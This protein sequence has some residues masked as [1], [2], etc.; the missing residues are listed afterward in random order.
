[1]NVACACQYSFTQQTRMMHTPL[2]AP[3]QK[4]AAIPRKSHPPINSGRGGNPR[5][6]HPG[7]PSANGAGIRRPKS[8]HHVARG[9]PPPPPSSWLPPVTFFPS[10]PPLL[11][12]WFRTSPTEASATPTTTNEDRR[13]TD[14]GFRA[15]PRPAPP[16]AS[17]YG[18]PLPPRQPLSL[19]CLLFDS[20]SRRGGPISPRAAAVAWVA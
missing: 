10:S 11:P 5:A 18:R 13:A 2:S 16:S 12:P 7:R 1:M 3:K 6:R 15:F 20:R 8:P 17:R 19:C 4:R 9:P 14:L